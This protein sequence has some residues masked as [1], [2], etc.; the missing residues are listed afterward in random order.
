MSKPSPREISAFKKT[1]WQHYASRGRTFPWRSR[2]TQYRVIVSEIMLQQTQAPR[3]IPKFNSFVRM[4]PNWQALAQATKR[5][6]LGVWQGLGYNRRALALKSI[7]QKI[8]SRYGGRLPRNLHGRTTRMNSRVSAMPRPVLFRPL[9][10][11]ALILL[12][13]PIFGRSIYTSSAAG[14][15]MCQTRCSCRS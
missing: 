11:I 9:P 2:P 6:I 15:R 1:I 12:S 10:L 8:D 14:V 3:V 4:F 5:D 13:R 7:A